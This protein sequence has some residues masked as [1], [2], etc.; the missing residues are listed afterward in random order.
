[1]TSTALFCACVSSALVYAG[2]RSGV[3]VGTQTKGGYPVA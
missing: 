2:F 1:M 3:R